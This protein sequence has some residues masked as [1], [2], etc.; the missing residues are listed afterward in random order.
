MAASVSQPHAPTPPAGAAATRRRLTQGRE[1]VWSWVKRY[2]VPATVIAFGSGLSL[3][4]WLGL[5][6]IPEPPPPSWLE[7]AGRQTA[8]TL[9]AVLPES[10]A[11][12]MRS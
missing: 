6:L 12:R 4:M 7:R 10:L 5:L 2:P 11:S 1:T 3:G 8:H 9:G